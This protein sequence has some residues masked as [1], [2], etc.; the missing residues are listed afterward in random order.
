[1][2]DDIG[3]RVSD[4]SKTY[5]SARRPLFRGLNFEMSRNGRLAVLGRN[6]QGKST[7]IKML[8]GI[9]APTE[10]RIDWQ[11]KSSW[12]IGFGGGF[13]GSLS[14][15]DNISFLSRLYGRNLQE[16]RDRVCL[17]YTS[18]SPRDS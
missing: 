2:P 15:L 6:G 10:G 13:Q 14:G 16:L 12:P 3:L 9:L 7:L 1:M 5:P 4:L 8:G 17:L 11:M 18:P